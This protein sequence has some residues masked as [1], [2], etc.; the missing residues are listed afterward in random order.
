L[1]SF[2]KNLLLYREPKG[3]GEKKNSSARKNQVRLRWHN[4]V[5]SSV[6]QTIQASRSFFNGLLISSP[7]MVAISPCMNAHGTLEP[8]SGHFSPLGQ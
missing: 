6:E 7:K 8:A 3:L 2:L 4:I 1:F 5:S